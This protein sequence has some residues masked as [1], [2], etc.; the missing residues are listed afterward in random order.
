MNAQ[1]TWNYKAS[2]EQFIAQ[3]K[4]RHRIQ[5]APTWVETSVAKTDRLK[6]IAGLNVNETYEVEVAAIDAQFNESVPAQGVITLVIPAPT[7][8]Q[9]IQV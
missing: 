2:D 9:I 6:M 5:G 1:V 4:V 8:L 7:N 3:F